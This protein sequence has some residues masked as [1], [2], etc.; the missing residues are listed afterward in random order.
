MMKNPENPS[1]A[2][3]YYELANAQRHDIEWEWMSEC[4]H[5][6]YLE[7]AEVLR[8]VEAHLKDGVD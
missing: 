2:E 8:I 1:V 7:R 5:G 3:I 6:E 4:D